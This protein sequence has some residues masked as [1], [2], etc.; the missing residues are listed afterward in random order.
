MSFLLGLFA[1]IAALLAL[2]YLFLILPRLSGGA[3]LQYLRTHYAHRGLWDANTP[4][5]SLAAF[6]KA[7]RAGVG[8]E[9]DVQL[10]RDGQVMV[11]HDDTLLRMCGVARA[12][13][14][15]RCAELQA[16]PL[17]R[18]AQ[19]VPT[20]AEVL[21]LVRGRVPLMIEC[22]GTV[23]NP[24]LC[25]AVAQLLDDYNGPFSV[26]SFNPLILRW[27]KRY[28]PS[29]AR[30]QLVTKVKRSDGAPNAAVA[31][32]L[33]HMLLNSLS[34]PDFLSV[35]LAIRRRPAFLLCRRLFGVVG[36]TFTVRS[37][38]EFLAARRSG[39]HAV[40]EQI[41]PRPKTILSSERKRKNI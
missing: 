32:L 28:R 21:A 36:F 26:I 2:S 35:D 24:A 10:S 8:I 38:H 13:K 9:L 7:L 15:L 34:R 25:R 31:F 20:L 19:T 40:F 4:E 23:E 5:N 6:A 12:V 14:D 16:L 29:F 27:F 3:D 39:W 41:R 17:K 33:S 11:F 18:S 37:A 1:L 30:G 22:K